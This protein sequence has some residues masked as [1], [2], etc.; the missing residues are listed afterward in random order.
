LSA[1]HHGSR[2]FFWKD[3][4]TDEDPYKEHLD[5]IGPTY[6]VV[7][8]PKEKENKHDHP[9]KEAMDL[10]KDEVGDDNVFHLGE[11]R[12]CII[13]D[14]N[15]DGGIDLYPDDDLVKEYGKKDSGGKG[16]GGK[17]IVPPPVSKIDKKPMGA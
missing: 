17:R 8:A 13:V 3:A 16:G 14:I 10:Y 2:S 1:A 9:H 7:S 4:D 12:E 11:K 15:A 6:V 5:N